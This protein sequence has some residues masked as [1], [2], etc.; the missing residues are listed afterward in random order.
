MLETTITQQNEVV[1]ILKDLYASFNKIQIKAY[2][3]L[4]Q[5]ILKVIAKT[6][7]HEDVA[8]WSNK[9][10]MYL[11]AQIALKQIP[12]TKEQDDLISSLSEQCKN[13]NLNYV[14]LAPIND[15]L[16]FD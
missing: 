16:Q 12:I 14:Y 6:E 2:L 5:T 4:E 10:V 1:S 3:P 11:Q 15:S 8:A 9:L 13:T 7:N